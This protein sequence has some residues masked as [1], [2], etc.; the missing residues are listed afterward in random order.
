MTAFNAVCAAV[1]PPVVAVAAVVAAVCAAVAAVPAVSAAVP[2]AVAAVFGVL[3]GIPVLR[4]RG[5]YLAIVTLAFG[6]I[7]KNLINI[8]Y[9]G[10]DD[11]GLHVATSAANL[12]LDPGGKQII[13]LFC[14]Y[15]D[16]FFIAN[17]PIPKRCIIIIQL[18]EI[19]DPK[20]LCYSKTSVTRIYNCPSLLGCVCCIERF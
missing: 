15:F 6:E 9:V 12:K 20:L 19:F 3:I 5:D 7:I 18:E 17:H 14:C 11:K 16:K 13:K 10:V 8:L 1:I 4:L 2:A